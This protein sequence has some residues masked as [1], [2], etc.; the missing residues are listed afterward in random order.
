MGGSV[1]YLSNEGGDSQ[2]NTNFNYLLEEYGIS[3]NAGFIV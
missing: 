2:L 3:V 1:L